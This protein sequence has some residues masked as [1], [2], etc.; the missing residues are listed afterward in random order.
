MSVPCYR[1]PTE[2]DLATIFTV[3]EQTGIAWL[4]FDSEAAVI[5]GLPVFGCGARGR[6]SAIPALCGADISGDRTSPATA[7]SSNALNRFQARLD[8][9]GKA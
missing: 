7:I 3:A 9:I 1:I 4:K 6:G 2:V 5:D 8:V